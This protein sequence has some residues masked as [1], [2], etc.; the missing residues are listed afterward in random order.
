MKAATPWAIGLALLALGLAARW[1]VRLRLNAL[2]RYAATL[3][4]R[5][6]DG[7]ASLAR[8]EAET[9]RKSAE[10]ERTV[11]ELERSE[12]RARL[13]QEEAERASQAKSA[14]LATMSH[15][16]RTP[17][18]AVIGMAELLRSTELRRDQ[19]DYVETLRTGADALLRVVSEVLDIS[20]IEAGRLEL[21]RVPFDVRGCLVDAVELVRSEAGRKGLKLSYAI[22]EQVPETIAGDFARLS[23]VL[24]NLLANAVKFTQ[25]QGEVCLTLACRARD[26][27][28]EEL[29]F[30]VHDSGIGVPAGRLEDIF[31]PFAQAD[32]STAR[33]F[34]GSG[35][36]LA[37]ARRLVEAMGGRI[38][39]ESAP[40][41]ASF[42]FSVP[43][44][45]SPAEEEGTRAAAQGEAATS[46]PAALRLESPPGSILLVEDNPIN[47]KVTLHML[48]RLGCAADL[49]GSGAE[50]FQALSRRPYDLLLIDLH[51]PDIDGIE[52]ARRVRAGAAQGRPRMV[53]LTASVLPELR[54]AC[55][56]AGMDTF[57]SKPVRLSELAQ[58]L[59]A[60]A[61]PRPSD[62][63]AGREPEDDFDPSRLA[64][65]AQVSQELVREV[66]EA[67]VG[68][69]PRRVRSLRER[70]AARDG[71]GL[72]LL[73]H[74]LKGAAGQ[75]GATRAA[76]ISTRLEDAADA[77]RFE[78]ALPLVGELDDALA[79]LRTVLAER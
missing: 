29:L 79:R 41:G 37:I 49:A 27:G 32:V 15:E 44:Q 36:G 33:H 24:L 59:S 62:L 34:G 10:L 12:Q 48:S 8:F 65:L 50:A 76:A 13:A 35:L 5:I 38:W 25:P 26:A 61:A 75:L 45:L 63:S 57:L 64:E 23:Q 28:G 54:E 78:E 21:E 17:L 6:Q 69:V 70:L 20:K 3:E 30:A 43:T 56:A 68:D 16:I 77:G 2:R 22:D 18:N 42:Y 58:A 11:A 46:A 7:T 72:A 71:P 14:F 4:A 31:E 51:M 74:S 66:V 53:A 60:P 55:F 67:F 52:L 19:A 47:Q 40:G 39:A 9:Q 1:I 73:A